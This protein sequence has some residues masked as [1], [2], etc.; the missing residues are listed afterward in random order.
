[1]VGKPLQLDLRLYLSLDPVQFHS[2]LLLQL[3]DRA[4][5]SLTVSKGK[6]NDRVDLAGGAGIYFAVLDLTRL[7]ETKVDDQSAIYL[8]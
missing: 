1:M 8:F 2:S 7:K 5:L 6:I 4:C 3:Y